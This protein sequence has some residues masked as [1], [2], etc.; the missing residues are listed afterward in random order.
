MNVS[1]DLKY[2]EKHEWVKIEGN[3][4]L[5]GI[6]DFA[7]NA[8]GDLVFIQLPKVGKKFNKN[9]SCVTLESVKAAEDVYAPIGG[10]VT[11]V[12]PSV[13]KDP[14]LVN[15][16]AYSSWMIKVTGFNQDEVQFLLS[17]DQYREFLKGLS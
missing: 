10:E 6:T 11:E 7:Q 3:S 16:D 15:K 5:I 1:N 14:S 2:T 4:A 9:E 13:E 12:N 17:P 8:L